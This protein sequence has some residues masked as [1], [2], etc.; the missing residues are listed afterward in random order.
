MA[1]V[2]KSPEVNGSAFSLGF[3]VANPEESRA[4][5]GASEKES[6]SA[7]GTVAEPFRT[8]ADKSA[9]D[10]ARQLEE[11]IRKRVDDTVTLKVQELHEK[12]LAEET[13][14]FEAASERGYQEGMRQAADAIETQQQALEERLA[15]LE[16]NITKAVS[17]AFANAT[18]LAC[19]IAFEAVLKILGREIAT[20]EAVAA[21]TR[22]VAIRTDA[23][24]EIVLRVNP[25]DA[26]LLSKR[27]EAPIPS[28]YRVEP[29][30]S[31]TRGGCVIETSHG[32]VDARLETRLDA[33]MVALRGSPS[34]HPEALQ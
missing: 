17:E 1:S 24:G 28:R 23:T 20:G 16:K 26:E 33:F 4:V 13:S 21:L 34:E 11:S 8:K 19:E 18:E 6:S 12:Q 30:E 25:L 15:L 22:E 9:E 14:L 5:R 2:I 29:D 32:I 3:T 10:A 7:P 27:S 31:L